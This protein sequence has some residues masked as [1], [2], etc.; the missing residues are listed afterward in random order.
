[1]TIVSSGGIL[2]VSSGMHL[3]NVE[4]DSGGEIVFAGGT[5]DQLVLAQGAIEAISGATVSGLKAGDYQS[6][7]V[8]KGQAIGS[9]LS[10][11]C[12]QD[13]LSGGD[14]PPHLS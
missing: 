4:V 5:V 12:E 1:M 11:Y 13:V 9:V 8:E 6:I 14:R 10:G 3:S 7:I 2:V